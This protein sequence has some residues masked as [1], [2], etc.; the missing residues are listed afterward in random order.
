M[1]DIKAVNITKSLLILKTLNLVLKS[2]Q[3]I[4]VRFGAASPQAAVDAI[5]R[6]LAP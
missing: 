3:T 1:R 4:A 5:S 2:G 6:H